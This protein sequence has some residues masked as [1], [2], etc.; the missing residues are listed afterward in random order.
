MADVGNHV[1][2]DR[3]RAGGTGATSSI[4]LVIQNTKGNTGG[5][6]VMIDIESR[7]LTRYCTHRVISLY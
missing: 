3:Q 7:T 5:V 2:H 6:V 4:D 1:A